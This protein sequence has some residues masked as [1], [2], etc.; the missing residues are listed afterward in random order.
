[1]HSHPTFSVELA[2]IIGKSGRDISQQ[3]ALSFIEGYALALDMTARDTQ[4]AAK[5]LG[6][7][8]TVAKG[9]D[10]FTPIR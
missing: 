6:L 8:W 10:T 9:Y 3:N 7:P 1:M 2:L 5:K 4:D